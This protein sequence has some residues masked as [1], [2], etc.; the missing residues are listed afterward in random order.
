MKE[1]IKEAPKKILFFLVRRR[2]LTVKK[3]YAPSVEQKHYSGDACPGFLFASGPKYSIL[4]RHI[5]FWRVGIPK[6]RE[7][8]T[9]AY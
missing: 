2:I 6:Y 1:H 5:L 9:F 7:I 4:Y 8:M 3:S